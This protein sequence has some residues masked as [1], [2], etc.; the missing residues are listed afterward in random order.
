MRER[1]VT[2][3]YCDHCDMSKGTRPAMVR[4]ER[5]CT[6]NPERACGMCEM[7]D[8]S[9]DLPAMLA[10]FEGFTDDPD[11]NSDELLNAHKKDKAARMAKLKEV[12]QDCPG[13]ILAVLRQREVYDA[14]FEW[15]TASAKW[16][17][18]H[19]RDDEAYYRSSC[20]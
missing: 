9:N 4:H 14:S 3:Y 10:I 2:R 15:K 20:Q 8:Q 19:P 12:A 7:A 6:L 18:D 16:L 1:K 17:A 13:C 11:F 5:G